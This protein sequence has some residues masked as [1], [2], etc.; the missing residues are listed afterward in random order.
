MKHHLDVLICRHDDG[1]NGGRGF[2]RVGGG[3]D[4][5]RDDHEW[6]WVRLSG[7]QGRCGR[8]VAVVASRG[9]GR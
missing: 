1:P 5:L 8:E 6:E 9:E 3:R 4:M 2:F 7:G